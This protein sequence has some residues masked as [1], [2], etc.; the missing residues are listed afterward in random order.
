[1]CYGVGSDIRVLNVTGMPGPR[2]RPGKPG[3][4]GIPGIPGINAWKVKVNG[5]DSNMLLIPPSI[6]GEYLAMTFVVCRA[7]Q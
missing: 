4:D 5:T 3:T 2:G 1:M 6:N 7:L